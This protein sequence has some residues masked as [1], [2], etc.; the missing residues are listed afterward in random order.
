[1]YKAIIQLTS[2]DIKVHR[3]MIRQ[4]NN[5]LDYF[6]GNIQVRIVCH[7]ASLP[8]CLNQSNPFRED[9]KSLLLRKVAV[10]VC[11]N[12]L[13]SNAKSESEL[14]VGLEI[15]PSAI[16]DLVIKQRQGWSY[17]KAG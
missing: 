13:V 7:G 3:S 4:V 11:H 1:M 5:L 2:D 10:A 17:V 8:F 12:M 14:I 6:S 15:I 9:I 16:A